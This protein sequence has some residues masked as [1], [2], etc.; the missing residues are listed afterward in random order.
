[1]IVRVARSVVEHTWRESIKSDLLLEKEAG[2]DLIF[3]EVRNRQRNNIQVKY[4]VVF[5]K[6]I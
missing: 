6:N 3:N 2:E 5:T 4:F 1:M